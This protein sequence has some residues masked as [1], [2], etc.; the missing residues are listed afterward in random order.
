[1]TNITKTNDGSYTLYSSHHDELYHSKHG[2][3][4]ESEYVFI[5]NGLKK[6]H[7]YKEISILELGFGTGL[8][9]LLTYLESKH[10]TILYTS[11]EA[12]PVPNTTHDQY[13]ETL[14]KEEQNSYQSIIKAPWDKHHDIS[15]NF[16]LHKQKS[17]FQTMKLTTTYDLVYADAFSPR[18][19]PECWTTDI[20]KKIYNHMNPNAILITYCSQGL[21]KRMLSKLGLTVQ[22]LPGPPGKRE[23]TLATKR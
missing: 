5:K 4:T 21:F 3:R 18:K 11:I 19:Q 10:Q 13:L 9:S 22:T 2:A 8:N 15:P 16:T 20:Y 14:P 12:Y 6:Y 7:H 23:M 17:L 1:M